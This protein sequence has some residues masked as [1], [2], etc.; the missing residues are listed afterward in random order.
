M[1]PAQHNIEHKLMT[2]TMPHRT[3][4]EH[5]ATCTDP[6]KHNPKYNTSQER[7]MPNT[8][9]QEP[10]CKNA[11]AEDY[12]NNNNLKSKTSETLPKM[13]RSMPP[14]CKPI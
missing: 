11:I 7:H 4:D 10:T 12:R 1:R 5:N 13:L 8:T 3:D 6:G 9:Q 14:E 2:N